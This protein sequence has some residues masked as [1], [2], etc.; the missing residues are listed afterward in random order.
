MFKYFSAAYWSGLVNAYSSSLP[1]TPIQG[2]KDASGTIT[3]IAQA[4]V[5]KELNVGSLYLDN[6]Y[7]AYSEF[8]LFI[9]TTNILTSFH[10]SVPSFG[11]VYLAAAFSVL[12]N[13]SYYGSNFHWAPGSN[14]TTPGLSVWGGFSKSNTSY[15]VGQ[16]FYEGNWIAGKIYPLTG[17]IYFPYNGQELNS[18]TYNYLSYW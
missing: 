1:C 5:N 17:F 4:Y 2:G 8:S 9:K 18:T 13:V 12:C 3:Y 6:P 7:D 11:K 15:Y 16:T 14:E 10:L